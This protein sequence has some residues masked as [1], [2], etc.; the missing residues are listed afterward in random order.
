MDKKETASDIIAELFLPSGGVNVHAM[1]VRAKRISEQKK[2][3][4]RDRDAIEV[5]VREVKELPSE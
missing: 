2:E 5:P 3:H 4:Q 1:A